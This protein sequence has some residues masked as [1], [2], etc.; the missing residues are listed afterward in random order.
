MLKEDKPLA[1]QLA[2]TET[3]YELSMAEPHPPPPRLLQRGLGTR[4]DT[5]MDPQACNRD[6]GPVSW[7]EPNTRCFA[8]GGD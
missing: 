4:Q 3:L 2:I 6:I 1:V 5:G 7:K 8:A